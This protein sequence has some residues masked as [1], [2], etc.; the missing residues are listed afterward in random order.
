MAIRVFGGVCGGGGEQLLLGRCNYM[1]R[2]TAAAT[3]PTA[4]AD[5]LAAAALEVG[6]G[7]GVDAEEEADEAMDVVDDE[8]ALP[9]AAVAE[10]DPQVTLA[11]SE[12]SEVSEASPGCETPSVHC[13]TALV[14]TTHSQH[15]SPSSW[16]LVWP[17]PSESCAQKSAVHSWPADA[18][19]SPKSL[20]AP[21]PL[22]LTCPS[23]STPGTLA[24][25]GSS[26]GYVGRAATPPTK[27]RPITRAAACI[28]GGWEEEWEEEGEV[29]C[30]RGG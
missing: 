29:G 8:E 9:G 22:G 13:T 3:A 28:V 5:T 20:L 18:K 11:Q 7:V 16:P 10:A 26:A 12:E 24:P 21:P 19:S 27:A 14:S 15:G 30:V 6:V 25:F 1:N 23:A 4:M 2:A 17:S